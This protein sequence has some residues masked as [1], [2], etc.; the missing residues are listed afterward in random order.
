MPEV[1][2]RA[3]SAATARSHV[4]DELAAGRGR[5]AVHARDHRLRQRAQASASRRL[6]RPNS[7]PMPRLGRVARSISF[8]SWPGAEARAG[9]GDDDDAHR[10]RRSRSRRARP[11]AR[12]A[13][14]ASSALNCAGR[15]SVSVA[16]PSRVRRAARRRLGRGF[17]R[18]SVHARPPI[19]SRWPTRPRS[20]S[21]NFWIL[22]VDVF[23]SSPKTTR[24]GTLKRARWRAAMLDQLGLGDRRAGLQLDERARRLAPLRVGLR[25]DRRGEHRRMAIEHVLDLERADVLAA[26]DDDVLRAVLDL[27]VAVRL[28][29]PRDRRSGTSRR[30][31]PRRSPSDSSGS[32]SS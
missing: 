13:S 23:G 9:A 3:S 20:R 25:D 11:A 29:A 18:R 31:T 21:T 19:R 32:P 10:R 15:F 12:S 28:H 30:R 8:R 14:R 5:D 26:G 2:K 16:T 17:E 4:D 27:D 24:F 1:A 7:S 22:P 6:Q